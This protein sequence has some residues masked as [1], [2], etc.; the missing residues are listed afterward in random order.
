MSIQARDCV[1]RIIPLMN[2]KILMSADLGNGH[3]TAWAGEA[4]AGK[5]GLSDAGAAGAQRAR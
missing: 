1:F 3:Q 5:C 2:H 4:S